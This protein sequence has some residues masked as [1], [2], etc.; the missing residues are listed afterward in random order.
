MELHLIVQLQDDDS[1]TELGEALKAALTDYSSDFNR[2]TFGPYTADD[3]DYHVHEHEHAPQ[4]GKIVRWR[5]TTQTEKLFE[6]WNMAD[7]Y[8]KAMAGAGNEV[9]LEPVYEGEI[10]EGALVE[11]DSGTESDLSL[12]PRPGESAQDV[13][14]R[15]ERAAKQQH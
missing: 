12:R 15:V 10:L 1:A 2:G 11:S 5:V 9:W 13:I 7:E 8:V 6:H 14:D 3:V 4:G